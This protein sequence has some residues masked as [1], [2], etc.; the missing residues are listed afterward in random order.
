MLLLYN[1]IILKINLLE[2]CANA[3][4]REAAAAGKD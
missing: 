4:I 3:S 2:S 1:D